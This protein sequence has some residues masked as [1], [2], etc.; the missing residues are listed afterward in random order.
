[1][2]FGTNYFELLFI[3]IKSYKFQVMR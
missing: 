1:M 2:I 3:G